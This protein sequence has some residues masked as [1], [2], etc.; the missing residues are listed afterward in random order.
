VTGR[1]YTEELAIKGG[2]LWGKGK[3]T[4]DTCRDAYKG[5]S[6]RITLSEG[7]IRLDDLTFSSTLGGG[8]RILSGVKWRWDYS[9]IRRCATK[10]QGQGKK[11]GKFSKLSEPSQGPAQRLCLKKKIMRRGSGAA[12]W[13]RGGRG[14]GRNNVSS[15]RP[16]GE[17]R[18]GLRFRTDGVKGWRMFMGLGREEGHR[19]GSTDPEMKK[20]RKSSSGGDPIDSNTSS[21]KREW[22]SV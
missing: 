15:G 8:G 20:S 14:E 10:R 21:T 9:Y 12:I 17:D 18:R 7:G 2:A 22:G 13:E 11:R 1:V 6:E 4:G 5:G 3:G 19:V 16:Q